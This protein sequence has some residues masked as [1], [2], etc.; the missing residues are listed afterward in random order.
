MLLLAHISD[1]HHG[2]SPRA[3]DR[4]ERVVGYLATLAVQPAA[5]LVSG[6]IADHGLPAEYEEAVGALAGLRAPVLVVPG[7]HDYRSAF[8]AAFPAPDGEPPEGP[9]NAV[10]DVGG[11]RIALCDSTIPGAGAGH[12]DDTTIAWLEALLVD[13]PAETPV[14]IAFHHPPVVLH[15]P[16][17]D[18]IRQHHP[19]KLHDLVRRHPQVAAIL[20]GHAHTAAVTTFAG[21]PCVVAPAVS[22]TLVLPW[23]ADAIVDYDSP[24]GVAFHVLDDDG[25]LTTH[26]RTV[27]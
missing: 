16:Y 3:R 7:N 2:G 1:L 26:F 5:V 23:V 15:H 27:G 21:V 9:I 20:C 17:L 10:A 24:P 11:V 4:V 19:D 13:T 6:D 8:R 14:L 12:L 18:G 25:R 22:S